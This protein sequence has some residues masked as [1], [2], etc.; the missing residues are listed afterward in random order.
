S[1]IGL[2]APDLEPA[3]A[4]LAFG[5]G[6]AARE[7]LATVFIQRRRVDLTGYLHAQTD[8]PRREYLGGQPDH[9]YRFTPAYDRLVAS[10]RAYT[11]ELVRGAEGLSTFQQRV[12][13]WAA[14]ALLR[15]VSSSPAAA[16]AA[17]RA[18]AARP[19]ALDPREADRLGQQAVFD[20]VPN[21]ERES[22][23]DDATTAADTTEE[24][25][26]PASSERHRL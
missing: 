25:A 21:D 5:A 3:V 4:Q 6:T 9:P 13:W 20:L 18:R 2:L 24:D 8:F 12:R 16:A 10:V 19:S 1:L 23:L 22:E 7:R 11:Q 15:C 14:L 17:L 26:T